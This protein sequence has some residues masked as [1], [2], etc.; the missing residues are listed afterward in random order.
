MQH[1][2]QHNEAVGKSVRV[3]NEVT[4][5]VFDDKVKEMGGVTVC[6]GKITI[7]LHHLPGMTD[8]AAIRDFLVDAIGLALKACYST[9]PD[10]F[11]PYR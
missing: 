6:G 11:D 7:T 4:A 5:S 10:A 2:D 3:K 8:D 1:S 9:K